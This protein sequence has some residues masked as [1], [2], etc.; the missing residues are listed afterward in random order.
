MLVLVSLFALALAGCGGGGGGSSAVPG[1]AVSAASVT[2]TPKT[3]RLGESSWVSGD[4]QISPGDILQVQVKLENTGGAITP[5]VKLILDNGISYKPGFTSVKY[6]NDEPNKDVSDDI[7]SATTTLGIALQQGQIVYLYL[8]VSADAGASG[9]KKIMVNVDG[10]VAPAKINVNISGSIVCQPVTNPTCAANQHLVAGANDA[11]GCPTVGTC[12]ANTCPVVTN[13]TCNIGYH[14]IPGAPDSNGCATAGTCVQD[15]CPV[16]TNPTCN[17]GYHLVA[18]AIVN[19]CAT[20]GTCVADAVQTGTVNVRSNL[21]VANVTVTCAGQSY[22]HYMNPT[23]DGWGFDATMNVGSCSLSNTALSGYTL[24][25]S[26]VTS[27]TLTV[28]TPLLLNLIYTPSG[29]GGAVCGNHIVESGETCD[30]G[31]TANGD[32]C[33][34]ACQ[35]EHIGPGEPRKAAKI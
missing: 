34:S 23:G 2:L 8:Y 17:A 29:G 27:G 9:M 19:G 31:N 11:N 24:S 15:A 3:A 30:D 21:N 22:S 5:G 25:S 26:S 4:R 16:V 12:V 28:I 32:G 7:N 13:P 35:T 33:S 6:S 14:L 18:G 1:P 20:A 10:A